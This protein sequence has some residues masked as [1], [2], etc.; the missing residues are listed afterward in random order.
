MQTL[1]DAVVDLVA[2]VSPS[3]V[4]TVASALRG[5]AAPKAAPNANTLADTPAARAAVARVVAAWGQEQASGDEVAGM[6]LGASEARLRV[7]REL[8][9]ELVWTGPT[10]RF[11]P[12][13]RTEQVL[14]DLIAS[15]TT[16]LFLVSFVAYDVH[17]VVTAMN[18]AASRGVRL[19]VL[20]EASKE[21]GGTLDKDLVP[22]MRAS[23]PTAEVFTWRERPEPFV[24]GKVHAK[25]AVVDGART[26][27][28]SANLTGHALEKNMEAGVLINGGP[29]PKTLRDHLQALIDVRVID[30]A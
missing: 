21:H 13:R 25:V 26:F 12:T 10:T 3:K 19:R 6:L 28:T 30:R 5:L 23:I 4:R 14:L 11:V 9:V 16:D 18:E 22:K 1:L 17:S 8:S 27:I 2:L 29:V 20:I 24:D 7:E 15:A